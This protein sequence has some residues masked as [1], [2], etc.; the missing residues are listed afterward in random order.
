[1]DF[2]YLQPCDGKMARAI[3]LVTEDDE[4]T[5][6]LGKSIMN[7]LSEEFIPKGDIISNSACFLITSYLLR[8]E[9][10]PMFKATFKV[11]RIAKEHK[12]PVVVC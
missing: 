11:V 2:F 1:M 5:F 9:N 12:I 10:A 8:D 3:C 6:A 4:R 7:E